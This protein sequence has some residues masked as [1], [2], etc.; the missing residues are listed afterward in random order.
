MVDEE[1]FTNAILNL[2]D[3]ANKYSPDA[4]DILVSTSNSN[5][6]ISISIQDHGIGMSKDVQKKIFDKFYRETS[7]NIHN[8][9]GFGLGLTYV[10]AILHVIKGKIKIHSEQGIGSTFEMIIPTID[11]HE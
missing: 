10:R 6:G 3:N 8:V 11:D 2:L 9:K 4:P 5:E 7:G 1:H